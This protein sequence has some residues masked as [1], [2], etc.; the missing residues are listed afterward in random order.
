MEGKKYNYV[1]LKS[2]L[3]SFTV[4][5]FWDSAPKACANFCTLAKTKFYDNCKFHRVEK[6]F[7]I[8]SGDPSGS[9]RGNNSIYGEGGFDHEF[10]NSVGHQ[11]AGILSTAS[12]FPNKCN[13]QFFITLKPSSFL[14]NFHTPFGKVTSGMDVVKRIGAIQVDKLSRPKEDIVILECLFPEEEKTQIEILAEK[15]GVILD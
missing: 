8:Q 13:S 6:D 10:S 4:L 5:L 9:G 15:A 3:G 1:T 7:V 12:R 14:D 11:E 2:T